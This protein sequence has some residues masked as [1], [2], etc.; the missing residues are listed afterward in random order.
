MEARRSARAPG[1]DD[2]PYAAMVADF[3]D[4]LVE[5]LL[6]ASAGTIMLAIVS[7]LATS[8]SSGST[9]KIR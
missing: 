7:S 3:A 9:A 4:E 5:M 6:A 8:Q 2:E 1:N